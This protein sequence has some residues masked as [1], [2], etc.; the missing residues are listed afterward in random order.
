MPRRRKPADQRELENKPEW[1]EGEL[2]EAPGANIESASGGADGETSQQPH[3]PGQAPT[4]IDKVTW[5]M[6]DLENERG[7][8]GEKQAKAEAKAEDEIGG[9]DRELE[10][11]RRY[12]ELLRETERQKAELQKYTDGFS[13]GDLQEMDKVEDPE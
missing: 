13:P 10:M 12:R 8:I 6:R 1:A 4:E 11:L 3:L 7:A 9:I 5:L 2:R